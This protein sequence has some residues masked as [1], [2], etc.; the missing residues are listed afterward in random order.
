[1]EPQG[2]SMMLMLPSDLPCQRTLPNLM[3]W[4]E[5][6]RPQAVMADAW[7]GQAVENWSNL[8]QPESLQKSETSCETSSPGE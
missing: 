4:N 1:V 5:L 3:N 6:Q 2:G 8:N 7:T